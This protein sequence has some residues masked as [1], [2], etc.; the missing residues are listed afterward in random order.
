MIVPYHIGMP[1]CAAQ[2]NRT[3]I[4]RSGSSARFTRSSLPLPLHPNQQTLSQAAWLAREVPQADITLHCTTAR[5]PAVKES[6]SMSGGHEPKRNAIHAITEARWL[7]AVLENMSEM[8]SAAAT[9]HLG[10]D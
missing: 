5:F 6:T 7:R 2:Q 10:A 8:A 4:A 9:M 3:S 1:R